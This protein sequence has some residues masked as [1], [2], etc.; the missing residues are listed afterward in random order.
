MV[1]TWHVQFDLVVMDAPLLMYKT[2]DNIGQARSSKNKYSVFSHRPE[3]R[4]FLESSRSGMTPA[5]LG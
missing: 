4:W 5:W 3:G 1:E 2:L